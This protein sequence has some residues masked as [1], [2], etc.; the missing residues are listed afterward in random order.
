MLGQCGTRPNARRPKG[1]ILTHIAR[2][3]QIDKSQY[4]K[5]IINWFYFCSGK[6][7]PHGSMR[8]F[9]VKLST[10]T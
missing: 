1:S 9:G 8:G 2:K 3:F 7:T 5:K 6:K 10:I 4:E